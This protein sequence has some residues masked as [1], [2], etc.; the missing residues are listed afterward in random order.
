MASLATFLWYAVGLLRGGQ[1]GYGPSVVHPPAQTRLGMLR[2]RRS[3]CQCQL[4]KTAGSLT[5]S[6]RDPPPVA[7]DRTHKIPA[8]EQSTSADLLA[9]GPRDACLTPSGIGKKGPQS[10]WALPAGSSPVHSTR[11]PLH[12]T[13]FSY[14]IINSLLLLSFALSSSPPAFQPP[15]QVKDL[16]PFPLLSTECSSSLTCHHPLNRPV[17]RNHWPAVLNPYSNAERTPLGLLT[18]RRSTPGTKSHSSN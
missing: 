17:G 11:N 6:R 2:A 8:P 18:G 13:H 9:A 5:R 3:E 1:W 14:R 16:V 10:L 12:T 7:Q 15:L 4:Q